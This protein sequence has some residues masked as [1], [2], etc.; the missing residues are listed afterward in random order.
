M[1][2]KTRDEEKKNG[3]EVVTSLL[4]EK[5]LRYFDFDMKRIFQNSMSREQAH[6]QFD[7][8]GY[9]LYNET[10]E[11]ADMSFL[12]KR[13]NKNETVITSG[14]THE[15]DST[16]LSMINGFNFEPTVHAYFKGREIDDLSTILTSWIRDSRER[17][18]YDEKKV[19]QNRAAIVQGTAFTREKFVETNLPN[20]L[21]LDSEID[22]TKLDELRFRN[23][24]VTKVSEGASCDYVDG[25]KIF[26][27]DIRQPDIR[28]QPRVYTVDYVPRDML[29]G[30]FG[31]SKRWQYVPQD[32]A[33]AGLD[34]IT[35]DSIYSDMRFYENDLEKIEIMETFDRT[36]NRYQIYLNRVPMLHCEFPLTAIS[37]KGIIPIAK[38]DI[39]PM[40]LFAYSKS[41]PAKTKIDQ[42]VFDM[43]L[44]ISIVKFKQSAFV[45]TANNTG[46]ILTSE[47][48]QPSAMIDDI[49]ADKL[50][51]LIDAPGVTQADFSF[52]N[53]FREMIDSKSLAALLEGQ[54]GGTNTLG[55]YLDQQKKASV[56]I[57]GVFDGI[58]NWEKQKVELRLYN[59]LANGARKL[60]GLR[61]YKDVY[62]KGETDTGEEGMNIIH[63]EDEVSKTPE[64]VFDMELEAEDAGYNERHYYLKAKNLKR[65]LTDPDFYFTFEI[66]P[67]DKNNDKLTKA[68]FVAEISQAQAIFGYDS[69]A[70]NK[71]KKKYARVMGHRFEDFFKTEEEIEMEQMEMQQQ[72]M[73]QQAQGIEAPKGGNE[74]VSP[75]EA[76]VDQM[77]T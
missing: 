64:E 9:M 63:I 36:E 70:V 73:E 6:A 74:K 15:K 60:T 58:I 52:L 20:K 12:A 19:L 46:K 76:M 71:L 28:L 59:L 49:E 66:T 77:Y 17:E 72:Q 65:M 56:K 21:I 43:M 69:L 42:A 48:Y 62:A 30:I 61:G 33:G 27:D 55:E 8:M 29:Y 50:K 75:R 68:M 41:L 39:S 35:S 34:F 14:I 31:K 1:N 37:P 11:K 7:G 10:N 3:N 18:R 40:N 16:L 25:K 4:T 51:P 47:I 44:K 32:N 5:E 45:P 54:S 13:R 2:P 24:G 38:G 22:F 23:D 53:F 67:V 26:L 57:G